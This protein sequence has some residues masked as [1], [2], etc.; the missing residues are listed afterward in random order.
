MPFW[1]YDNLVTEIKKR[2]G[3]YK[4]DIRAVLEALPDALLE[5]PL[6]A[7]VKTPLGVFRPRYNKSRTMVLPDNET[8][9]PVREKIIVKLK[10]G[11]R[12]KRMN[13]D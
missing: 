3:V 11:W 4:K 7:W 9:V 5:I 10:P 13:R 12:L 1:P 2:S 6:G 8:E